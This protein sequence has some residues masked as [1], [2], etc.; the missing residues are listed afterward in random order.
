MLGPRRELGEDGEGEILNEQ[1]YI[2]IVAHDVSELESR[3]NK[4]IKQGYRP[5][6][7]V[8]IS[9]EGAAGDMAQAMVRNEE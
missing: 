5:I 1:E 8:C 3:V 7:G 2:I 9:Y 6:G 4:W